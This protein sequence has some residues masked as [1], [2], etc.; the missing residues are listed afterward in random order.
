VASILV[1]EH[2]RVIQFENMNIELILSVSYTTKDLV[3]KLKYD[4]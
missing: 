1:R 4:T 3:R 2:C